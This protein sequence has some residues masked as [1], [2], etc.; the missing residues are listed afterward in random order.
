MIEHGAQ[1]AKQRNADQTET[2]KE[3]RQV[4]QALNASD[5]RSTPD[6]DP[7]R[8]SW[9]GTQ[10]DLGPTDT[11]DSVNS[12][13]DRPPDEPDDVPADAQQQPCDQR[14]K[15]QLERP[16]ER[17]PAKHVA[18]GQQRQQQGSNQRDAQHPCQTRNRGRGCHF[19]F[20]RDPTRAFNRFG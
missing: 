16:G 5:R 17:E 19:A 20:E 2:R 8:A 18:Y 1:D 14:R 10:A 13:A 3:I 15:Q 7:Q 6:T 11:I 4:D 12:S 9:V